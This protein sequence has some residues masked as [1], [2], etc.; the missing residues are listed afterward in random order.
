MHL[1][2]CSYV[3]SQTASQ[4]KEEVATKIRVLSE[5]KQVLQT[6]PISLDMFA[7]VF[8]QVASF[9]RGQGVYLVGVFVFSAGE[10]K[11]L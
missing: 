5:E 9:G 10:Q 8:G 11:Y 7:K 4:S 3:L 2:L 6:R 1:C